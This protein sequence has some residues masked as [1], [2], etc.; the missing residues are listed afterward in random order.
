MQR[1]P[2]RAASR[3]A[4]RRR[5]AKARVPNDVARRVRDGHPW[6]FA[7]ALRGAPVPGSPGKVVEV[8]D[9]SGGFVG[10][11]LAAPGERPAL[12][13]FSRTQGAR[14]DADHVLGAVQRAAAARRRLLSL[15]PLSA[16][17]LLNGDSEGVPGVSVDWYGGYAVAC[18]TSAV[19]D[20]HHQWLLDALSATVRPK[21]VYVQQRYLP[22]D[23]GKPRPSATLVLGAPAPAEVEVEEENTRYL[24]DVT[25]PAGTGLFLDMRPGRAAVA[26]LAPGAR[27]LNCF[28]YTG[29][30]SVVAARAGARAVVSVD[31]AARAH[32][33]ARK[34]F[35]QNGLDPGDRAYEF[36]TGDTFAVLSQLE[37]R[38]RRFE[39]VVLDP[40]TFSSAKKGRSFTALKDYTEL[41]AAAL[42]VTAP[43]GTLCVACNA[44][45]LPESDLERAVGQGAARVG[46][47]L[48][49]VEHLGQ[50]PDYPHL[51]GFPEGKHLKVLILRV[52]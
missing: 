5:E 9:R 14:F 19:A 43:G 42:Q 41:T 36:V 30:F 10:Q 24:V 3:S 48:L 20:N 7:D 51:P 4:P 31:A 11:A 29:A 13:V 1:K 35:Q 40:P 18:Y 27:V 8:V 47:E 38:Q 26:R 37:N 49:V 22:P 52:I 44:A 46:R 28:S 21:A 25:A 50:G 34:N 39:L 17:R 45:K 16:Y 33:R 32:G 12:R 2:G 15:G 6:I 23:P